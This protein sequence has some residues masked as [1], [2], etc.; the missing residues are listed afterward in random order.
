MQFIDITLPITRETSEVAKNDELK[1][2]VGH[3]GTHFDVMGKEFP[4]EYSERVGVVFDVSGVQDRDIRISDIDLDL[5]GKGMF[6]GF[7]T[8]FIEKVGYGSKG[9]FSEHPQLSV[10]LIDALVEKGVSIV[11]LDFAGIRRPPEHT[12]TDARLANVGTF[13]VEN[14]CGLDALVACDQPLIVCTYP[15]KFVGLT[16]L[17]CRVIAHV[18]QR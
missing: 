13:V 5:V 3:I 9:Y 10:E 14:L 11:G 15:M 8:G 1:G 7:R 18:D 17:P 4:L 2:L 12:P 16:G 6:V